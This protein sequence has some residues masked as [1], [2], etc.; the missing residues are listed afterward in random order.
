MRKA[1]LFLILI[2]LSLACCTPKTKTSDNEEFCDSISLKM[3]EF[4]T[5]DIYEDYDSTSIAHLDSAL[6]LIDSYEDMC[7]KYKS[8]F[9]MRRIVIFSMK[10]D[11]QKALDYAMDMDTSIFQPQYK[12]IIINR[13]QAMISQSKGDTV[14]RNRYI[15]NILDEINKHLT[16]SE[17]DSVINTKDADSII[18]YEK[19]L[20]IMQYF[21]YQAQLKGFDYVENYLQTRYNDPENNFLWVIKENRDFLFFEGW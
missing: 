8:T 19:S 16:L 17:I 20:L 7:P 15:E 9:Y 3:A 12:T 11:Y 10:K 5:S 13:L 21:N 18:S 2:G 6:L 1:L 4:I 14:A